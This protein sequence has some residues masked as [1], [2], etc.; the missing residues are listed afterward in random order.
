MVNLLYASN[1]GY[2]LISGGGEPF[3]K[4]NTFLRQWNLLSLIKLL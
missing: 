2:L 3:E 1:N 4:K